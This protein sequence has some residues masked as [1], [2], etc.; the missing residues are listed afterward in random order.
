MKLIY[1]VAFVTLIGG[2]AQGIKNNESFE[3][4]AW[5]FDHQVQ[6]DQ[7]KLDDN[8]YFVRVRSTSRTRFSTLA[9][10]L[11]RQSLT[12]CKSYGFKIEILDG[13]ESYNEEKY[14][15]SYIASSLEANIECPDSK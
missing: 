5:D 6:F 13:V 10:F 11:V 4:K 2:C 1:V 8:K 14:Y 15:D 9:T 12:V 3:G 7:Q